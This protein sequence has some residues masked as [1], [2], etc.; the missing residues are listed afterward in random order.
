M[1][2]IRIVQLSISRVVVRFKN[3]RDNATLKEF[4]EK[5]DKKEFIKDNFLSRRKLAK[6]NNY[7]YNV[8]YVY[9]YW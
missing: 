6:F 1:I 2:Y 7:K 8:W 5:R 4:I 9:I 3:V